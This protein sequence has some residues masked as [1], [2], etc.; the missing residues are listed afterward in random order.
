MVKSNIKSLEVFTVVN[1]V[2]LI[3]ILVISIYK[4]VEKESFTNLPTIN[5]NEPI[6]TFPLEGNPS[7]P[8]ATK[9]PPKVVK[10]MEAKANKMVPTNYKPV[11]VK[12]SSNVQKV[13]PNLASA[14]ITG[15]MGEAVEY[16][17]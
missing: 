10:M 6:M 15:L 8:L 12:A 1:T 4:L 13:D 14:P 2:L 7:D 11:S 9:P 5:P 17:M 3:A 16:I